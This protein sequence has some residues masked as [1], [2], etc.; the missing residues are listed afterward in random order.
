MNRAS[1]LQTTKILP[2]YFHKHLDPTLSSNL[3]TKIQSAK[4]DRTKLKIFNRSFSRTEIILFCLLV[5]TIVAYSISLAI[6]KNRSK[7]KAPIVS[8]DDFEKWICSDVTIS[9]PH[10]NSCFY[11]YMTNHFTGDNMTLNV[12]ITNVGFP[13]RVSKFEDEVAHHWYF[14]R[15]TNQSYRIHNRFLKN[16]YS[17]N[18][19]NTTKTE[20]IFMRQTT[21]SPEQYWRLLQNADG[22]VRLYNEMKGDT[23]YLDVYNGYNVPFMGSN[24]HDYTGQRWEFHPIGRISS[25]LT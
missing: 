24:E 5:I 6:E 15:L 9:R 21:I 13:L 7:K 1:D 11:Y 8:F 20:Q 19:I 18:A 17:M 25:F 3:V 23:S 4:T 14:I 2:Q 16:D 10:P 12:D 22:S